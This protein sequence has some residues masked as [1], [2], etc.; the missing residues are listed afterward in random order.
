MMKY[1]T[2][3][4]I[5]IVFCCITLVL[6]SYTV[7]GHNRRNIRGGSGYNCCDHTKNYRQG[8]NNKYSYKHNYGHSCRGDKKDYGIYMRFYRYT[9]GFRYKT[10]GYKRYGCR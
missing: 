8:N 5:L 3:Y 6:S 10:H 4:L 1:I 7:Y 2:K 9:P